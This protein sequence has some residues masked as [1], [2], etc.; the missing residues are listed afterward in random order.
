MLVVDGAIEKLADHTE[1]VDR[2]NYNRTAG[3]QSEYQ[4]E[5]TCSGEVVGHT[6]LE[7]ADEDCHFSHESRKTGETERCETCDDVAY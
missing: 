4:T 3:N 5:R 2:C 6:G 1:D 7:R